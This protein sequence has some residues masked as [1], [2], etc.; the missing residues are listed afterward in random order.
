MGPLLADLLT[1]AVGDELAQLTV[2]SALAGRLDWV[3]AGWAAAGVSSSDVGEMATDLVAATWE[4]VALRAG[5]PTRPP[6]RLAWEIVDAARARVRVARRRVLRA[7]ARTVELDRLVSVADPEADPAGRNP[8]L[9]ELIA[10]A[11]RVGRISPSAA[12]TVFLTR[13]A[14]YRVG[15]AAERLGFTPTAA[16]V[17]R[18]RAEQ[19]LV[20][21]DGEAA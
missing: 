10:D 3:T 2:V 9:A 15:E 4:V 17:A 14:G 12:A 11:I 6:D 7:E 13:V 21:G 18:W 5:P 19:R 8:A 20:A 16:R 1:V